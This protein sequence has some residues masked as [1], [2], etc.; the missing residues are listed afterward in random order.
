MRTLTLNNSQS[1]LIFT[2]MNDKH[3]KLQAKICGAR[4]S[5]AVFCVKCER[6]RNVS[7]MHQTHRMITILSFSTNFNLN[8]KCERFRQKRSNKLY[9]DIPLLEKY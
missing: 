3:I 8:T 6:S 4:S 7:I 9:C 5:F 2:L 1:N